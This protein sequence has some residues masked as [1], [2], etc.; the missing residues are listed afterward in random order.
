MCLC[1]ASCY[2]HTIV[3]LVYSIFYKKAAIYPLSA[4]TGIFRR[5]LPGCLAKGT[6]FYEKL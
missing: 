1:S 3:Q 2:H 6:L 5:L 4:A